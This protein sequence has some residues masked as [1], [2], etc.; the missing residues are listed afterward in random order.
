MRLPKTLTPAKHAELAELLD[1]AEQDLFRVLVAM[2]KAYGVTDQAVKPLEKWLH[3][4][5]G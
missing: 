4:R 2:Q 3:Q 1:R 5:A